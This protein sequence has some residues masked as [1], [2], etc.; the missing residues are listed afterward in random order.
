MLILLFLLLAYGTP[1]VLGYLCY[2]LWSLWQGNVKLHPRGALYPAILRALCVLTPCI[3][4]VLGHLNLT[5]YPAA[6]MA[7]MFLGVPVFF[8]TAMELARARVIRKHQQR[9]LF[10]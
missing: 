4:L 3:A 1:F 8:L 6:I 9:G 10:R 7:S 2:W 5:S